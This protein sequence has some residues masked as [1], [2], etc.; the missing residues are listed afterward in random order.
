MKRK[1]DALVVN[2]TTRE[3]IIEGIAAQLMAEECLTSMPWFYKL[4]EELKCKYR[5]R[6]EDVL[7]L[8]VE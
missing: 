4:E 7:R 8:E 6:A 3:L 1:V 2:A 5:A